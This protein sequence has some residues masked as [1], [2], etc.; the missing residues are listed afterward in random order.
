MVVVLL[1]VSVT[2]SLYFIGLEC[3]AKSESDFLLPKT[4]SCIVR[5]LGSWPFRQSRSS[6]VEHLLDMEVVGG[7]IPLATTN[8]LTDG[9]H[10][11]SEP[12]RML[13]F[14]GSTVGVISLSVLVVV[15]LL[16]QTIS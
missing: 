11:G 1:M 10:C 13:V 5:A 2:I 9:I 8:L 6:V 4:S 14:L 7:S 12:S 15:F 16:L 3:I